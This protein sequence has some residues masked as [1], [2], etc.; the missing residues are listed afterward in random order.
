MEHRHKLLF[1]ALIV[2]AVAGAIVLLAPGG[3]VS[4]ADNGIIHVDAD[5]DPGGDGTSWETAYTDLQDALADAD[6][7]QQIWVAA[8]TYKPTSGAERTASFQLVNGVA[9]YGGFDPSAGA[10]DWEHRDWVLHETILSGDIGDEATNDDNVYHV[11]TGREITQLAVLDGFVITGGYARNAPEP[12]YRYGGGLFAYDAQLRLADL[13]FEGNSA[14][15]SG[16]GLYANSSNATLTNVAFSSNSADRGGGFCVNS[17]QATLTNCSFDDNSATFY[18][19]GIYNN[20]S[21]PTLTNCSFDDNSA[22]VYGGGIYNWNSSPALTN[23]T[24]CGNSADIGGGMHNHDNSSPTLTNCTFSGNSAASY[25]GGMSNY[26]SSSPTLTNCTFSGNS[27]GY[28][29][30]IINYYSSPTLTNCILWGNEAPD[31]A[32]IYNLASTPVVTYS[33]IQGNDPYP[34]TDNINA[35]PLFVDPDNGDFH[36]GPGSP[37]IDAGTN[38]APDPPGLP[39]Y[40]FEGDARILDGDH[41]GTPVVDMGV[42]ELYE[43]PPPVIFV[44]L[45]A[46]GANDSTSWED[47]LTNLQAA[48]AWAEEGVEIWVA[49][50][51]YT[52]TQESSPGDPRSATFQMVN[53]VALYGGFDPSTGATEWEHRD[54]QANPTILSG[55]IGTP[56]DADDN[57]YHVFYHP[58][59]LALDSTAILDGFTIT[60]GN[61]DG[62]TWPHWDGGGMYNHSSSPKLANLIFLANLGD[63]GAGLYNWQSSA[64]QLTNCIFSGNSADYSGGGMFNNSDSSP[65]L[66]GCT[67]TGNSASTVGGGMYNKNGSSPA[68]TNCTFSG[69]EATE[70]GGGIHNYDSSPTLTNCILWG[71][72]P[73]EI[74]ND[75]SAPVVTYSDI[76]GADPYPGAGNI[77]ADPLFL[78]PDNGDFHLGPGSPCIDVGINEVPDP[79]GLPDHDFE[80][81]PRIMDGDHDGLPTVDM[82]VDEAFG[83]RVHLPLVLRAY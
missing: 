54:W 15:A 82:G 5:A 67:F 14:E 37:C 48:L 29:G 8:G 24:F 66:T 60:S 44:D 69:N 51:T 23:C 16:G 7:G 53:G 49:A 38:D 10:T 25:G 32:Q 11:L 79:P 40:D 68:L 9:I 28:G 65:T 4:L 59:E 27:A 39:E 56:G 33:D 42:D 50:G 36:L 58:E 19:G 43:A 63:H 75:S 47:A 22:T 13:S 74:T 30:G 45:D 52:P 73:N 77:K 62:D 35:D 2:V 78:D 26:S 61:A 64:P 12:D 17:S 81:D 55:D 20:Y 57:V 3:Q 72:A 46:T 70:S 34:G 83:Y 76:Q 31:R 71:D 18:G 6:P 80:G 21:S 1:A 41:D